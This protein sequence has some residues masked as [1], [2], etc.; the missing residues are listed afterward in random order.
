MKTYISS[1]TATRIPSI[2]PTLPI[3]SLWTN[4]IATARE[5]STNSE[6][7]PYKMI[8]SILQDKPGISTYSWYFLKE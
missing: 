8:T 4:K 5:G 6:K 3:F 7:H 1:H 2:V